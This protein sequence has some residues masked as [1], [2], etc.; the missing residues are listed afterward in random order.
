MR[1][2]IAESIFL[3]HCAASYGVMLA[4]WVVAAVLGVAPMTLLSMGASVLIAP[5]S[6]PMWLFVATPID[7]LFDHGGRVTVRVLPGVPNE[8]AAPLALL[9]YAALFAGVFRPVRRRRLRRHRRALGLCPG[10][11]YD[12]RASRDAGRCPECG[13]AVPP[14]GP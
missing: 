9:L 8:A 10:G 1:R 12:L 5:L 2:L 14:G 13:E 6:V 11:A 4:L 7:F 3:A